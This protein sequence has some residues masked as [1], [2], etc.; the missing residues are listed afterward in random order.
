LKPTG[1]SCFIAYISGSSKSVYS[2]PPGRTKAEGQSPAGEACT[3]EY[4][5]KLNVPLPPQLVSSRSA[6]LEFL[7]SSDEKAIQEALLHE[8]QET[9]LTELLE[10]QQG[11]KPETLLWVRGTIEQGEFGDIMRFGLGVQKAFSKAGWGTIGLKDTDGYDAAESNNYC[12]GLPGGVA[13]IPWLNQQVAKCPNT[14]FILGG[15][16]QGAMVSRICIAFANEAA[17]KQVKVSTI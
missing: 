1:Q 8:T 6:L 10:K 4:L 12:V 9:Q 3:R 5:K 13:C 11:C 7:A 14:K 16:S 15:Y 17:K 2:L